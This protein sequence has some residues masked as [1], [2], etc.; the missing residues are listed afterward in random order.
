MLS[1]AILSVSI[2]SADMLPVGIP[3][4]GILCANSCRRTI[5]HLTV[6]D[7]TVTGV[8]HFFCLRF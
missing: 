4:V 7:F 2:M 5:G 8:F 1:V 6:G 3:S